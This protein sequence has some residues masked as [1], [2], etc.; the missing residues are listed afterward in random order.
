ML[1][2]SANQIL[3][4]KPR[5]GYFRWVICGLL[6]LATVIN[7]TDRQVLGILAPTLQKDIGW[8]ESEYGLI[9]TAFSLAYAIAFLIWGNVID[10]V[11]TR[12][13]FGA[14]IIVWSIA[15]MAHALA[16][17]PL[18]FALARFGL[19]LGEAGNFPSAI[20]T[21]AEWFPKKERA[22]A[23]GIFN[24][25]ANVGAIVA[26]LMVPWLTINYGWG[27][28]FIVTG[29]LG[30]IWFILWFSIYRP[31]QEHPRVSKVE[32]DYIM[33]DPVD[34]PVKVRWG[35]LL[36]HKQTWAFAIAKFMTDPIWWFYLYWLPKFLYAEHGI[37]LSQLALPLIV[38]YVVAD[39]G[40]IIGGWFSGWLIKRGWSVP[41]GRKTAMLVCAL[42]VTPIMFASGV[43]G[44][45]VAVGL[46][47]LAASAHQG[48]SANLFTTTSDMFPRKTV[49]SV[50]GIGGFAGAVGGM[51]F[52]T[53]TGYIL[54]WTGNNYLP[55]FIICGIAY[56]GALA[57][58][59]LL[60]PNLETAKIEGNAVA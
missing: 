40:S 52:Q 36:K 51:V 42:A 54:E 19:G 50:V 56:L 34:P 6:F 29:G 49:A 38:V 18:T 27:M 48:W 37:E 60:A 31:A 15:A 53:T 7:Y 44:L 45:W 16:K 17:T 58:I 39:G 21:V 20:K 12:I 22:L 41:K 13:G 33:S 2:D 28:A 26:P 47:S 57:V 46:V 9:V 4:K 24:G 8:S 14:A 1:T 3:D 10:K 59:Q 23:T 43:S 11:G 25:G 5:V 55:M 35:E 30:F 32:L